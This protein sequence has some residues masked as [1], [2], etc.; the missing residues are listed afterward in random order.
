MNLQVAQ[1]AGNFWLSVS[2][3]EPCSVEL[4]KTRNQSQ[5]V[6]LCDVTVSTQTQKR[7]DVMLG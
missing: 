2:P 3:E 7:S 5:F 6:K 4:M 1:T